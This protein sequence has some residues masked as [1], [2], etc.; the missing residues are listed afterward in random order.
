MS[1]LSALAS[2]GF[3]VGMWI[4]NEQVNGK[5]EAESTAEVSAV[6]AQAAADETAK[7]AKAAPVPP[8]NPLTEEEIAANRAEAKARL[9]QDG[10]LGQLQITEAAAQATNPTGAEPLLLD[11]AKGDVD[12]LDDDDD[13]LDDA[14]KSEDEEGDSSGNPTPV[15][16]SEQK[17]QVDELKRRD[18]EVRTHEQA[19]VAAA[20]GMAGAPVYEYQTGPDGV[21]Y[22]VGGHVDIKTSGS[23][24][25]AQALREAEILKRAA[26]A[27]AEP[28]PQD[29]AVAAR[30]SADIQRFKAEIARGLKSA[31]EMA[32]AKGSKPSQSTNS[33]S[34]TG[35]TDEIDATD[36]A[37]KTASSSAQG[38]APKSQSKQGQTVSTLYN[39]SSVSQQAAGSY[40]AVESLSS[41]ASQP[42]RSFAVQA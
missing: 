37:G 13:P 38:P 39:G 28:S 7:A 2:L 21:S 6:D 35:A 18:L 32:L 3:S 29:E 22:A 12:S 31:Q 25:P 33:A 4:Y 41:S 34:I 9:E 40:A 27:P 5:D 19:H 23:S 14:K 24:D 15:L 42:S 30:A 17:K 26:T 20:A 36:E 8:V 10:T 11:S 16:T 1:Y